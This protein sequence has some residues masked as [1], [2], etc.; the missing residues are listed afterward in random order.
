MLAGASPVWKRILSELAQTQAVRRRV[1][2]LDPMLSLL[3]PSQ[4]LALSPDAALFA[5]EMDRELPELR[6]T[7][8]DLHAEVERLDASFDAAFDR[9]LSLPP[10]TFWERREAARVASIL[11]NTRGE[12]PADPF[13]ELPL[14]H[15]YRAAVRALG[16]FGSDL[17]GDLPPLALA[18][19]YG[20]F[21]RSPFAFARGAQEIDELLQERIVSHGGVLR[22]DA[23]ISRIILRGSAID[24][25]QVEGDLDPTGASFIVSDQTGQDL[26]ELANLETGL[27]REWPRIERAAGRFVMSVVVRTKGLPEPLGREILILPTLGEGHPPLHVVRM[28]PAMQPE[29]R[30]QAGIESLLVV[31][32]LLPLMRPGPIS[33]GE[34]RGY[35]L[36][37]L[38]EQLPFLDRHLVA[39]DSPHD[40][41][42]AWKWVDGRRVEVERIHL[43]GA[44]TRAEPMRPKYTVPS[45]GWLGLGGEPLRGPLPRTF[46]TGSSVLPALGQE[47]QLIAASS[48]ARI[49][50]R[51]D[52]HKAR[53]RK[54]MWSRVEIG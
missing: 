46:L 30:A 20:S 8:D 44:S 21:T 35:V 25:V 49:I 11:S 42:P 41:H 48:V 27:P 39:A 32:M 54:A 13:G 45:P 38:S 22:L 15:P 36:R 50:T 1:E 40:G 51:A 17:M 16:Q 29:A 9:D 24:A 7:L 34:A 18:R 47:G 53:I 33:L 19:L 2:A 31:E 37:T 12:G 6:R 14:G 28:D 43:D 5:R 3:L 23:R 10:G 52:R 26:A 4:R